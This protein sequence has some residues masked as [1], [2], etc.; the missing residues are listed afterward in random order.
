MI[1]P[2]LRLLLATAAAVA[3]A[4]VARGTR[5]PAQ[6]AGISA[7]ARSTCATTQSGELYCWGDGRE[8]QLGR[9]SAISARHPVQVLGTYDSQQVSVGGDFACQILARGQQLGVQ[10]IFA[11]W[12]ERHRGAARHR[13]GRPRPVSQEVRAPDGLTRVEVGSA[14]ACALG[15]GGDAWCWGD[16]RVGQLGDGSSVPQTATPQ[17]VPG[18]S[19][20]TDLALGDQHA[21]GLRADGTVVCWGFTSDGRTGQPEVPPVANPSTVPALSG[22]VDVTAGATHTCALKADGTV[23]CFGQNDRGQLGLGGNP[24]GSVGVP[25]QVTGLPA[26][27]PHRCWGP[28]DLR[29]RP[30][31]RR[32]VLGRRSPGQARQRRRD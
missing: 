32:V 18:V 15:A 27:Q 9:V 10:G 5:P 13:Q 29:H 11:C 1:P 14:T 30:W 31:W 28:L 6:F 25:T 20:L 26:N 23:W 4:V 3:A 24:G 21:C 8:G 12:W 19:G 7:G 16:D 22:V 2:R 17:Q